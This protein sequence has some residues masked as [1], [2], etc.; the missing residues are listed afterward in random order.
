MEWQPA[1]NQLEVL[2][3]E[4]L[5]AFWFPVVLWTVF[6]VLAMSILNKWNRGAALYHYHIRAALLLGLPAGLFAL[7]FAGW[8]E[9]QLAKTPVFITPV[10]SLESPLTVTAETA[11]VA[12]IE[13]IPFLIGAG[14]LVLAVIAFWKVVQFLSDSVRLISYRRGVIGGALE[15]EKLNPANRKLLHSSRFSPS[16]VCSPTAEVPFTYGWI[17]PLIVV[18]AMLNASPVKLNLAVRHELIHIQRGDYL[19]NMLLTLTKALFWFHPLIYPLINQIRTYREISCDQAVLEDG[20][21]SRKTYAQLLYELAPRSTRTRNAV[22]NMSIDPSN[23]KKR[24]KTLK[25]RK[26]QHHPFKKS[27]SFLLIILFSTALAMSCSDMQ[28]SQEESDPTTQTP[29][30]SESTSD[31]TEE[32][33]DFYVVVEDMPE[34]IGGLQSVQERIAYPE[35]AQEEGVEGRV[36]VQFIVNE[37]GK[38]EDPKII[39]GIGSGCDEEA[40]EAVKA[41]EFKPGKQRGKNVRVQYSLPVIFKLN[42]QQQSGTGT[43]EQPEV[44]GKDMEFRNLSSP[45]EGTITGTLYDKTNNRPLSG[46]NITIGSTNKGTATDSEGHFIIENIPSGKQELHASFVGYNFLTAEV[47]S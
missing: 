29:S 19:L 17:H 10:W 39:R 28:S 13:W 38:V 20:K 11:E 24:I 6:T 46:A 35:E 5:G 26:D 9:Q 2:G 4:S 43:L 33:D 34:L 31:S 47:E 42:N 16:V 14:M 37:E 40:L 32:S 23:L 7:Y 44:I 21:I 36:V 30:N 41:A 25:T 15:P 1:V 18:P 22:V 8:I 27:L 12:S 45:R 3:A